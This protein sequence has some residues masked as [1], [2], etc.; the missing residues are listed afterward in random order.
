MFNFPR[1]NNMLKRR[2]LLKLAA[3]LPL[4]SVPSIFAAET[5]NWDETVDVL[6][7]GGGMAG[8]TAA[9]SARQS[10]AK[11]VLLLEKAPFLGGHS[12]MSGS[13]Y[14]I[15]GS[16]IQKNAGI[17]D[18]LEI[19]WKDAVDRGTAANRFIKRDIAVARQV[20]EKGVD[21]MKWLQS[22]GVTFT[23]KP[24]QGIGNRKRVHYVAPGYKK[25]SPELIKALNKAAL[26][27]G[28]IIRTN[29]RL[30]SLIQ[31]SKEFG[32]PVIGAVVREKD[33][34]LRIRAEGGVILATG[35][36]ANGPEL[37]KK[38]H[39]YLQNVP[40]LGS[41]MNVGDGIKAATAIGAQMIVETNGFGMNML[42]V[43]THKGQSMGLPLT[44]AP[45]IVV[46]KEGQRFQDESRGYLACTHKMVEKG[47]KVAYWIF[48][49]K[50][51]DKFRNG[52]LKP[53]FE[54][55]VVHEYP[56]LEALAKGE[57]ISE[58]GLLTTISEYNEDVV[59]G[60]DRYFGRS[61][62]LQQVSE[63]P[64]FAFE[65]EPR[66]YT[67]YSGLEINTKAQ[68]MDTRGLAI[69]GLYAAGDVTGH[70][71]YQANLGG[72]G[73]SGLSMAAVYGRIAGAQAAKQ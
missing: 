30:A 6:V 62:L 32:A 50:T 42:F 2:G 27:N 58:K 44:E 66:I 4:L 47:Y 14:Y 3:V 29:A 36:F 53:L 41:K 37:V 54:T 61:K 60:K 46:N 40:S 26:D 10:G 49:K 19:N 1:S 23:N 68:V 34:T 8:L 51:S 25:G 72:G 24:V 5:D 59:K 65:A 12:V 31:K 9:I 17:E 39:P 11:K 70:L 57:G 69:P 63:G 67:S 7:F 21:T 16:D 48:D 55:E 33:K 22:L 45:I 71:V 64:F 43:G 18:S 13:G 35:G 52:C 28:V 15:G 56:S 73:I 38:Y 20:Y